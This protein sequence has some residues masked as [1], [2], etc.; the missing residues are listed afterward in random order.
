MYLKIQAESNANLC[1]YAS[2]N[3][4]CVI[5]GAKQTEIW[6][7]PACP[8]ACYLRHPSSLWVLAVLICTVFLHRRVCSSLP[9]RLVW[10]F[11]APPTFQKPHF[12]LDPAFQDL[13][14]W[15]SP[16]GKNVTLDDHDLVT[17]LHLLFWLIGRLLCDMTI[18]N[19]LIF[20]LVK[21]KSE[22]KKKKK[23]QEYCLYSPSG[24]FVVAKITEI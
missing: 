12:L 9:W 2:G 8:G 11:T 18:L 17:Q 22:L 7:W 13:S 6:G 3:T 1:K 19:S 10:A 5:F 20:K 23:K 21:S 24:N 15:G 4:E 16:W 14:F